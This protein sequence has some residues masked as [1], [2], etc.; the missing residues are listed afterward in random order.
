MKQPTTLAAIVEDAIG[1]YYDH[2]VE[3]GAIDED[4]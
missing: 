1:I 3:A 2:L 4:P